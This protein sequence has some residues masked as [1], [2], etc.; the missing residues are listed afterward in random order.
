[1]I[2]SILTTLDLSDEF[3]SELD[4]L[5]LEISFKFFSFKTLSQRL[6]GLNDIKNLITKSEHHTKLM[7]MDED[8]SY[9]LT[10]KTMTEWF[11]TNNFIELLYDSKRHPELIKRS[12]E[13]ATF[14][15]Q[16]DGLTTQDIDI[17][18]DK[19]MNKHESEVLIIYSN[20]MS[21]SQ[22]LSYD[23]VDHL[24]QKIKKI[25]FDH[26]DTNLLQLINSL[27]IAGIRVA[28]VC[29]PPSFPSCFFSFMLQNSLFL[30]DTVTKQQQQQQQQTKDIQNFFGVE[31]LWDFILYSE[32]D[33]LVLDESKIQRLSDM[34]TQAQSYL[35]Y[36][37]E[38]EH[39]QSL[40]FV[41]HPF[42]RKKKKKL[43]IFMDGILVIL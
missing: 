15:A 28:F 22:H 41:L 32:N 43:T 19:N 37:I 30:V 18:W 5:N 36:F 25:H 31:L 33:D 2:E 20:F 1:M 23:L 13:I 4:R 3:S 34:R 9:W 40:R 21:L 10:V 26:Y 42:G 38:W 6:A 16:N 11:R 39:C 17:M 12:S 27:T 7:L 29:L 35:E 14:L 24:Y 8:E